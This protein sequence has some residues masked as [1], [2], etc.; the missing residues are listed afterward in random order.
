MAIF[1]KQ[2]AIE[3]EACSVGQLNIAVFTNV[4]IDVII[5]VH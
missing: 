1:A 5:L 4:A 2:M 3:W